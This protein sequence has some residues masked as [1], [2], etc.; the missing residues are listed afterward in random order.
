MELTPEQLRRQADERSLGFTSTTELDPAGASLAQDRAEHALD[1]SM[2]MR[3]E[4]YNLYALG[5]P[6]IGMHDFVLERLQ[7]RAAQEEAPADWCYLN[8]FD[9]PTRAQICRLPQGIGRRFRQDMAEFVSA[10]R[11]TLPAA[12][13]S[14]EFRRQSAEIGQRLQQRQ[15]ADTAE[16]Q[17]QAESMNLT[18]LPTP[19]G[20][21]F[22]PV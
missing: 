5:A 22:A 19:N 7:R 16:L 2:S 4:G 12:L 1:F 9:D 6:Q 18:M 20:F 3:F 11:H 17:Q 15:M 14:D 8:N 13:T 10:V 21:V